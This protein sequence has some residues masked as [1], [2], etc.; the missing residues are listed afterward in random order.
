ML[1]PTITMRAMRQQLSSSFEIC[2]GIEAWLISAHPKDRGNLLSK[3][4][5]RNYTDAVA[6]A[7]T[8]S[9]VCLTHRGRPSTI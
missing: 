1:K 6:S 7:T 3:Q 9:G 8:S 2:G 5:D 4:M